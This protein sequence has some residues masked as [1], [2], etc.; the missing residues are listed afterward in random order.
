MNSTEKTKFLVCDSRHSLYW[1]GTLANQWTQDWRCG[2][3]FSTQEAAK[4]AFEATR[5]RFVAWSTID[6]VPMTM[7]SSE[8]EPLVAP[9]GEASDFGAIRF[10]LE[11][12]APQAALLLHA[13]FCG[14][15]RITVEQVVLKPGG[16]WPNGCSDPDEFVW[17]QRK[18]DEWELCL[19]GRGLLS[20]VTEKLGG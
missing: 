2:A 16:S 18:P 17:R 7:D 8:P 3:Q 5:K 11:I 4:E 12:A 9:Q 19:V 6:I 1:T 13:T 14:A 10:R 20:A 15:C